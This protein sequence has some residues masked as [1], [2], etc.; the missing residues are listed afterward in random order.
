ML[1]LKQLR[2]FINLCGKIHFK[3]LEQTHTQTN[4]SD[5]NPPKLIHPF[6]LWK[7]SFLVYEVYESVCI[8][9][10]SRNFTSYVLKVMILPTDS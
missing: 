6:T 3:L 4:F 1:T 5:A 9:E 7:F 2:M 8:L 10:V